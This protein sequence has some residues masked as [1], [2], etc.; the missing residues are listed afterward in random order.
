MTVFVTTSVWTGQECIY[1]IYL[2]KEVRILKKK[3][4]ILAA[5][6]LLISS[7]SSS[8]GADQNEKYIVTAYCPCNECSEGYESMT[9]TGVKAKAGNTIAV[10]PDVIPYGSTVVIYYD[11]ELIGIFTAEDCG[12]A[13]KGKKIDIYFDNHDETIKWGRKKCIAKVYPNAKG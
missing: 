1:A 5:A 3:L 7:I 4:S 8:A 12:G 9:S 13:I 6:A 11:K 10:D 2:G